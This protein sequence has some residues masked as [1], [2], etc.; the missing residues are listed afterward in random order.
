[1]D[2]DPKSNPNENPLSK[3]LDIAPASKANPN[4]NLKSPSRSDVDANDGGGSDAEINALRKGRAG[5]ILG[6]GSLAAIAGFG[7]YAYL[8]MNATDPSIIDVAEVAPT[9]V[10]AGL[11]TSTA[12]APAL[13]PAPGS[14]SIKKIA[15][16]YPEVAKWI[17][18]AD[19][20]SR[21]AAAVNLIDEG[22]SP[23]PMLGFFK[24]PGTFRVR[25]LKSPSSNAAP[26]GAI[27]ECAQGCAITDETFARYDTLVSTVTAVNSADL[28]AMYGLFRPQLNAAYAVIARPGKS[29]DLTLAHVLHRLASVK[30]PDGPIEVIPV[31]ALYAFSDPS[32][33]SLGAPEKHLLRMGP[34]NARAIQSAIVRFAEAA[35]LEL[36]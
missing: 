25:E 32:L 4:W 19:F 33:E 27:A 24:V 9:P 13:A 17:D 36:K 34:Q 2:L 12:P 3:P 14:P 15:S 20:P 29:F 22:E 10:D 30:I 6:F 11:A 5:W 28:A 18:V 8:E 31:G 35:D 16:A 26:R 7:I 23:R 1:M 21:A